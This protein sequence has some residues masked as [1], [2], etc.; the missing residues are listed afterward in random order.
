METGKDMPTLW[1]GWKTVRLIGRG[2]FG[3]VYE[4]ERDMLGE[5][6]KAAL[7]VITIP[8]SDGDIRE[9]V[10]D[11]Y[12]EES[13][14]STFKEHLKSIVAEYSL[15]RKLNGSANVVNCDDVR[16]VQHDDGIGWDIFIKMELLTPLTEALPLSAP[17]EEIARVGRDLCRA[18]VQCR[19]FDIVHRDIKP[20]NIF[21]SP[22]GDY[23]L[24]DF[25][26]AKTVEKTSG[27]TKIGTYKYM[28]PEVYNNRPYGAG[29]DIYSLGL[30]LYWLLNERRLPF[31]P[32]PPEK[33]TTGLEEK[34]RLRRFSGEEIP[35][36]AHGGEELKR[37]VLK[38]CAFDPK[39]RWQSAEDMLRELEKLCHPELF[40]ASPAAVS[41]PVGAAAG[42]SSADDEGTT[43]GVFKPAAPVP[44]A[45][46]PVSPAPAGAGVPDG[47]SPDDGDGTIGV[48]SRKI[49]KTPAPASAGAG[50][51]DGLSVDGEDGTIGVFSRKIDKTPAPASAEAGVPDGPSVDDDATVPVATYTPR[52]QKAAPAEAPKKKFPLWIPIVG[53]LA[54]AAIL[55]LVLLPKNGPTPAATQT[56]TPASAPAPTPWVEGDWDWSLDDGVLTVYG[57]GSM[58][59]YEW[60][61]A[62]WYEMRV[63]IRRVVIGNGIT[64][65]GSYAFAQCSL[66]SVEIPSSVTTI[67]DYAFAWCQSL[68]SVE[69]PEGVTTVGHDAFWN[70]NGLM[71]V[72]IPSSVTS[73]GE[74][75]FCAGSNLAEIKV[76]PGNTRYRSEDGVLFTGDGETLL[77]Y[78]AKKADESYRIPSG[79]TTVS[80]NAFSG[81]GFLVSVE[82][83]SSVTVIDG[84]AFE[85]CTALRSVE[86]PEGVTTVGVSAFWNCT[87]LVSA[88]IPSSVTSIGDGAFAFCGKLKAIEVDPGNPWYKEEGGVLFSSD[89]SSLLC[90]PAGKTGKS[91]KIPS[92]VTA[93]GNYAFSCCTA[94]RS[95]T[96]PSS[97]TAIGYDAF[98]YCQ[99]LASVEIPE[100]M[101]A[102]GEWAFESCAALRSVKIP[103]SVTTVSRGA[104]YGCDALKDVYYAGSAE[105]WAAVYVD[106]Y[107]DPLLNATIRFNSK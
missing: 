15:M 56:P 91:Y 33:L 58:A 27:G 10:S 17:A 11:G 39:D 1:P 74:R 47:P 36:P 103:S 29:A 25:G 22:L 67:G 12:D 65:I 96:I 49:D 63:S 77:C 76:D 9:M 69:I 57:T 46:A 80:A 6:E 92:G 104:F 99:S 20:Q 38:A 13:I 24:G 102:I 40:P 54:V 3:A 4:I 71:S 16:Y 70:C 89:G 73:I 55:L 48:F 35:A 41:A 59:N 105:Q 85:S 18:L 93:I 83:P 78:P 5:K 45:P 52:A 30:V 100:G 60:G 43:I 61:E 94:L 19:R 2:S 81:S 86:L 95:V 50:V 32:L 64:E 42:R 79:V 14:T 62:P 21:V 68:S 34:A 97:V 90:Y 28:A 107:N 8:Q 31:L 106:E 87:G 84:G 98:Y 53:V 44:P 88:S 26:V 82:I 23:K 51:P 75:A 37:I 66:E 101:T 7:K 72:T